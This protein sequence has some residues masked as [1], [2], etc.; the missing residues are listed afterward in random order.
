MFGDFTQSDTQDTETDVY[1]DDATY[2]GTSLAAAK[3]A[4][5]AAK[6][7]DEKAAAV[8]AAVEAY[9]T[10][11]A[12][13]TGSGTAA[14]KLAAQAKAVKVYN[15]NKATIDDGLDNDDDATTTDVDETAVKTALATTWPT[16]LTTAWTKFA[17]P[18]STDATAQTAATTAAAISKNYAD[19]ITAAGIEESALSG[20]TEKKALA[21]NDVLN[22][23]EKM[24][25]LEIGLVKVDDKADTTGLANDE[26]AAAIKAKLAA[27]GIADITVALT[28][29]NDATVGAAKGTAKDIKVGDDV[30]CS[31]TKEGYSKAAQAII[32]ANK[33]SI[34]NEF[35]SA[36]LQILV[37]RE[38]AKT[39]VTAASELPSAIAA[40]VVAAVNAET[41]AGTLKGVTNITADQVSYE[42]PEGSDW[43]SGEAVKVTISKLMV[44]DR[45]YN[46]SNL[47][48]DLK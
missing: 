1:P 37:Q 46:F 32:D 43:K 26:V 15:D 6:A 9:R 2:G 36:G 17:N 16:A 44:G 35:S 24:K 39:S 27:A 5:T 11:N 25:T 28:G 18:D 21:A 41:S 7:A 29:S 30:K 31:L 40:K 4:A 45:E 23:V 19:W 33:L 13:V 14:E 10:A 34:L 3:A 12:V 22:A 47:S 42:A 38:V 20:W 48:F 8:E